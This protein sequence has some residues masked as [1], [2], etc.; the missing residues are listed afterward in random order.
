MKQPA[1]HWP[2]AEQKLV[3]L[4]VA[5]SGADVSDVV[6][7]AGWQVWHGSDTAAPGTYTLPPMKHPCPQAPALHTLPSPHAV[8]SC[9]L[10]QADVLSVGWQ[11]WHGVFGLMAPVCE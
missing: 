8:P 3:G 2:V 5:P 6:L 1:T 11:L 4:Q 10:L 9:A 7:S